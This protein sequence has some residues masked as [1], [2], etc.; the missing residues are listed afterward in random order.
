MPAA[1]PEIFDIVIAGGGIVGLALGAALADATRGGARVLV[2]DPGLDKREA[3]DRA[4]AIA[5]G[6]RILF[7]KLGA[8]PAIMPLAEPILSMEIM[9]GRGL[10]RG[11]MEGDT[12]VRDSGGVAI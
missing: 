12:E 2:V 6:S 9:D 5:A 1:A 11:H 8:W 7:E 4:V 10:Y 3:S